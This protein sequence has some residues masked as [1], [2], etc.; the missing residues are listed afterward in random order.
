MASPSATLND[1]IL[2][3][4]RIPFSLTSLIA[5]E[6]PYS[7]LQEANPDD[8]TTADDQQYDNGHME[9]GCAFL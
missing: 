4:G 1:N 5:N 7:P 2:C 8:S 3:T 9:P 6:N